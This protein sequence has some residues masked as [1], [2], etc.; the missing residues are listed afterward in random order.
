MTP[1]SISIAAR[2]QPVSAGS[3]RARGFTLVELIVVL[4]IVGVLA[5]LGS[6]IIV[7]P[8][9]ATEDISRRGQLVDAADL[10]LERMAREVR[11]AVPNTVRV[12]SSGDR[13]AVEFVPSLTGGRY[14]RY[15]DPDTT[16]DDPINLAPQT[17]T[18]DVLGGLPQYDDVG[19]GGTDC[20]TGD[21][22]CMNIYNTGQSGFDLYAGDNLARISD[23]PS[24]PGDKL[25]FTRVGSGGPTFRSHSPR[26]R[27]YL[28]DTVKSFVCNT[29][30]GRLTLHEG[31][32]LDDTQ[33]TTPGGDTALVADGVEECDFEYQ[34]G[35]ATRSGLLT[36][37]MRIA[38]DEG[39]SITLFKQIHVLNAP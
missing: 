36:V 1:D 34:S 14:R 3:L 4:T 22:T 25:E 7:Q 8:F 33:S 6:V 38:R 17:D 29:A 2:R 31:Y 9:L 28:F 15:N 16:D 39:E 23:Q 26:Q 32:G 35:T 13:V 19:T 5:V 10:A 18:F 30:N 11:L 27:F 21:A 12:E 20:G 24:G 37:V